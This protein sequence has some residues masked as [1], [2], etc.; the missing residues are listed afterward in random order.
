MAD[1]QATA[2]KS[3]EVLAAEKMS[4]IVKLCDVIVGNEEDLQKGLGI[5]GVE[6]ERT[7]TQQNS[8]CNGPGCLSICLHSLAVRYMT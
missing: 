5:E 2:S 4:E 7:S 3:G 8:F 1:N 6:V